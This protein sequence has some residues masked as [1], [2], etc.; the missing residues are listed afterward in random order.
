[1]GSNMAEHRDRN[2]QA[3]PT[4]EEANGPDVAAR[5]DMRPHGELPFRQAVQAPLEDSAARIERLLRTLAEAE[6]A[7]KR[8]ERMAAEARQYAIGDFARDL[9]AVADTLDRALAAAAARGS[10]GSEASI[11]DGVRATRRMLHSLIE[12]YGVRKID[13]LGAYFDPKLHEA[14]MVVDDDAEEPGVI[15]EVAEDGYMLHDRLLRPARVF[16]NNPNRPAMNLRGEE[17]G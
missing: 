7:R 15:V 17:P 10:P 12:R 11:L 14:V 1:M 8:A 16:V 9:L 4:I 13:S 2:G 6:N 5:S 3:L